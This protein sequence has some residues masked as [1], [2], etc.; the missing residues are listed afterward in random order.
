MNIKVASLKIG[1]VGLGRMGHAIAYRLIQGGHQ[2]VGFDASQQAQDDAQ[3][4]GVTCV[5]TLGELAQQVRIFWL[6]VP[7]GDV[8]DQVIAS[9]LVHM[10]PED[11]I[12]DGGNSLFH[13]S[14]RRHDELRVKNIHFL[15]CGTSGGLLG[16]EIGFSL[17]IGGDQEIFKKL[18]PVFDA[19]AAQNGYAYLGPSGAGHYVK[20]VHN[21]IEY[22]LLQA[23]AEGFHLLAKQ[24]HY[25]NLDLAQ[26]SGVW[27]HG[28]VIR[29][30]ILDLAHNVF[31]KDQK[32]DG[33]SGEIGENLTGRWTLDEAKKQGV[34]VDLIERALEIR[35]LSRQTGG[36]YG[37]KVVALLRNQFGG[38]AV[39][40]ISDQKK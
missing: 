4:I 3:K 1:V 13:D 17:M 19:I 30:W 36:N 27:R 26:V 32:L 25:K 35:A 12:I 14:L 11:I 16:Q 9:L 8:V 18:I 39:K 23:Y 10:R 20:M 37:T 15:D 5:Q 29:S 6:M 24:S 38:H 28:S 31:L 34:P 40:K 33:I 21:G 22:A 7:A 2:V